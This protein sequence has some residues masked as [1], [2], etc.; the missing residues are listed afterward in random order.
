[1]K[2]YGNFNTIGIQSQLSTASEALV[3]TQ[4]GFI[5]NVAHRIRELG[6][7]HSNLRSSIQA[8]WEILARIAEENRDAKPI[9]KGGVFDAD[10]TYGTRRI[11]SL[12]DGRI[13]ITRGVVIHY[14]PDPTL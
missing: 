4:A 3:Q 13:E 2:I 1:M 9:I 14:L 6:G 10:P 5:L 11:I 7:L 8:N 12:A